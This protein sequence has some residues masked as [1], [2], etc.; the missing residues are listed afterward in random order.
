[1]STPQDRPGAES[2]AEAS[3]YAEPEEI[4]DLEAS[5]SDQQDVVG[6]RYLKYGGT[7]D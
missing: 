2:G 7:R 1:M 4:E 5:A 6:G 3:E